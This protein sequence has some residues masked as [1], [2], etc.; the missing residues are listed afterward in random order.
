MITPACGVGAIK[1]HKAERIF[2]LLSGLSAI[3]SETRS[4]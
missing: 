1:P 3:M 4:D 2:E